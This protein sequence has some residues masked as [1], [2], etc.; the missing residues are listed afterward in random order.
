MQST[1]ASIAAMNGG[2]WSA[3]MSPQSEPITGRPRCASTGACPLPGKCLAQAETPPACMPRMRAA[4]R[5]E[6]S[7]GSLP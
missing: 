7:A 5:R 2:R 6:T 3:C 4:P 1:P